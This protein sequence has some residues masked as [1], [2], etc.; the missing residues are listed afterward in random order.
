MKK[1]EGKQGKKKIWKVTLIISLIIAILIAG[2]VGGY[3]YYRYYQKEQ[4]RIALLKKEKEEKKLLEAITASYGEYVTIVN[5]AKLYKLEDKKYIEVGQISKASYIV[6]EQ[7][8]EVSLTDTYFKL[9]NLDYY[10]S[11]KDTKPTEA[12]NIND[13]YKNYVP[14]DFDIVTK[15]PTNFYLDEKLVYTIN[16]SLQLPVIINDDNTYYVEFDNRLYQVKKEDVESTVEVP[17]NAEVATKIGVLN[18]HFFY[19]PNLGESCNETICLKTSKFEEQLQYLKNNGFYTATMKDMS[20]WME[21]KIRLPKKTTVLTVDDG[22]MGTGT[23]NGNK[24]IPLLEKY[25]LHATLFLITA[26]WPEA[27]YISPNLEVQS[28]GHNIHDFTQAVRPALK[29]TKDQLLND[30]KLSID[31][32]GGENTAFC[33]PFYAYNNTV[34]EAVKESGFKIAFVGGNVKSTQNNNPYL[35]NRYVILSNISLNTFINMVN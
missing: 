3:L 26:W 11:Y 32:L 4:E 21:K 8:G 1:K 9:Q 10:V 13:D 22:A 5:D 31:S 23:E 6:L 30:F 33:Y 12:Q 2:S 17:R 19:D 7:K 27:N 28:H 20:L 14:F 35:I 16:S 24:L 34:I 15:N 18:Y 25:D 29:M